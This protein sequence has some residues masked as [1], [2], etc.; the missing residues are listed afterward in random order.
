[1][2][3]AELKL[4]ELEELKMD[5]GQRIHEL[6]KQERLKQK[7]TKEE[8][9]KMFTRYGFHVPKGVTIWKLTDSQHCGG[10]GMEVGSYVHSCHIETT[11]FKV[12]LYV[13][14]H[15]TGVESYDEMW[16]RDPIVV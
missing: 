7:H 12:L 16:L 3:V 2:N 6:E 8:I 1:M 4:H 13:D 10:Y 5:I 11:D 9:V 14:G 15:N